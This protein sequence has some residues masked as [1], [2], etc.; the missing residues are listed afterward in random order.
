MSPRER[1][2]YTVLQA[3][4]D[5]WTERQP[6]L[7]NAGALRQLARE[8]YE[9]LR[10]ST[11]ERRRLRYGDID[12]DCEYRV[13][14]TEAAVSTRARLIGTLAGSLYQPTEP[15]V[16]REMLSSLP[17]DYRDFTFIDIGS[18]KG[19]TLLM[20]SDFRFR[21]IIGVELLPELH[22]IAQE[23]IRK[24]K[25]DNQKS[26]AI[27]SQCVDARQFVFPLDPLVLYLFNPLP[28]SGMKAVIANLKQSL[29]ER[30]RDVYF[31]YHNP[32]HRALLDHSS[33][34]EFAV[35]NQFVIYRTV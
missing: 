16:F 2:S 1:H 31:V 6:R 7:G 11:P 4:R 34:R 9:F 30:P 27:E 25:S 20:A 19:R 15:A 3:L 12:Y 14:T 26:F 23:N 10:D 32:E 35:S 28:E 21:R 5:W 17:I 8:T 22:L 24:Y 33:L 29:R 18:G 13:N